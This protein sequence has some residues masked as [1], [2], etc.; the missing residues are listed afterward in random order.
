MR[1]V[2]YTSMTPRENRIESLLPRGGKCT[3]FGG[4]GEEPFNKVVT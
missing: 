4:T 3:G 2:G 1:A